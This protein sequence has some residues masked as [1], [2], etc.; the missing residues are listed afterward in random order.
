MSAVGRGGQSRWQ[1]TLWLLMGVA[2]FVLIISAA[3]VTSLT[4]MRGVR[5]GHELLVRTALGA[6][7]A[8]LRR[9][10]LVENL[11]VAVT[12]LNVQ[13]IVVGAVIKPTGG[14]VVIGRISRGFV[15][16]HVDRT[17]HFVD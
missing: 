14:V 11:L 8:R 16:W 6:G 3:N 13:R 10:L 17:P 2:A 5:R 15:P 9:L 12:A 4:L 1:L 7:S